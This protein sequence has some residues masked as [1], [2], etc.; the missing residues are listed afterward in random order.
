M[1]RNVPVPFLGEGQ[2]QRWP[3]TRLRAVVPER[4]T[5]AGTHV[6]RVVVK[7]AGTFTIETSHGKV[8]DVPHRYC[9]LLHRSD[10]YAYHQEARIA[11][12]PTSQ[13]GAPVSAPV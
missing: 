6:G 7:A 13:K 10:G 3:L 2:W 4:L 9:R 11:P 12:P 8:T 1:N 5:C